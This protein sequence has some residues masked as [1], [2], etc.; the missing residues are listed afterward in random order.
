MMLNVENILP[1]ALVQ[2]IPLKGKTIHG[3]LNTEAA[4]FLRKSSHMNQFGLQMT[5]LLKA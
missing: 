3:L 1:K 2:N 5:K 4:G